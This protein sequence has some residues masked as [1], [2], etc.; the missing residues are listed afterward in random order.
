MVFS[1]RQQVCAERVIMGVLNILC[2]R[3]L[4]PRRFLFTLTKV[5]N[6]PFPVILRYTTTQRFDFA[7]RSVATGREVWR[8]SFNRFFAQVIE[9]IRLRPGQETSQTVEWDGTNNFGVPVPGG[10]YI[11]R[12]ENLARVRRVDQPGEIDV[13][14]QGGEAMAKMPQL[15]AEFTLSANASS[16]QPSTVHTVQPG[17]TLWAIAR[18][19]GTT[20][21]TLKSINSLVSSNIKVG[22]LI[23]VR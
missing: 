17:D 14:P 9:E 3:R 15:Q 8:W 2:V 23:K 11:L 12:G 21:S 5:N 22:Q 1:S 18:Q 10:R 19:Y 20:V 13:I 4:G 7:V 16:Q 6:N